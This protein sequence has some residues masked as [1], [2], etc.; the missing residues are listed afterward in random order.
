[1][2][3]NVKLRR[4]TSWP[5]WSRTSH[6][7]S[8]RAWRILPFA[9]LCFALVAAC[10]PLISPYQ[11]EAYRNATTLKARSLA[12]IDKSGTP[13]SRNRQ[14]VEMLM[15][16]V[17]AAFEYAN[18]LPQNRIVAEQWDILRSDD[19]LLGAFVR[20]WEQRGTIQPRFLR[21]EYKA[22]IGAAFDK[23]ICLEVNKRS[24]AAC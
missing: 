17:D 1:M 18:G 14:S 23:I 13:F 7:T 12:L 6:S 8:R 20:T 9:L 2:N 10:T 11:E 16:D 4:C 15:V 22:Q 3:A 19:V 24:A 21:N 5:D